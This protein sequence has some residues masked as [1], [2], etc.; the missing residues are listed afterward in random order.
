M[1]MDSVCFNGLGKGCWFLRRFLKRLEVR[2]N[3]DGGSLMGNYSMEMVEGGGGLF[4]AKV[5]MGIH[6]ILL[7]KSWISIVEW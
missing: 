3:F 4:E 1:C 7:V 5:L 6:N 2:F